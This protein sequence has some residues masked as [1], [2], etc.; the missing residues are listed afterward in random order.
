MVSNECA[1]GIIPLYEASNSASVSNSESGPAVHQQPDMLVQLRSVGLCSAQ[2][3]HRSESGYIPSATASHIK[4]AHIAE[5]QTCNG[6]FCL[7]APAG[8]CPDLL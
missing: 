5:R 8:C 1:N 3:L 2:H 4:A 7:L 6:V